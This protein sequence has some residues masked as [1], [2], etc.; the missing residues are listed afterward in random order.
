[1][2]R[3]ICYLIVIDRIKIQKKYKKHYL[4][5]FLKLF[6]IFTIKKKR[7]SGLK[8]NN[9]G[10]KITHISA[11]IIALRNEFSISQKELGIALGVTQTSVQR[12]E[13]DNGTLLYEAVIFFADKYNINPAWVMLQENSQVEKLLLKKTVKKK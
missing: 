2:N 1:M 3:Y 8:K 4:S 7:A 6:F 12:A 10:R 9:P 13:K 11:R 5:V